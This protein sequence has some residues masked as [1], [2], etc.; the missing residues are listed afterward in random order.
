MLQNQPESL[1]NLVKRSSK[2]NVQS[3]AGEMKL[4]ERQELEKNSIST[5]IAVK[6]RLGSSK[7]SARIPE[8][9]RDLNHSVP[10]RFQPVKQKWILEKLEFLIRT[11]LSKEIE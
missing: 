7:D 4:L 8:M 10:S 11:N 1:R 9:K 5:R 2:L 6:I 3:T